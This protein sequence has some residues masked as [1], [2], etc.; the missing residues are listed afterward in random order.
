MAY[1]HLIIFTGSFVAFFLSL[2]LFAKKSVT[3]PDLY[4]AAFL[5]SIGLFQLLHYLRVEGIMREHLPHLLRVRFL[6]HGFTGVFFYQHIKSG[7]KQPQS[8]K[9]LILTYL[10][11]IFCFALVLPYLLHNATF[12]RTWEFS[13]YSPTPYYLNYLI[14]RGSLLYFCLMAWTNIKKTEGQINPDTFKWLIYLTITTFISSLITSIITF[15]DLVLIDFVSYHWL[16]LANTV[17]I[18]VIAIEAIRKGKLVNTSVDQ[19]KKERYQSSTLAE[20]KAVQ[21]LNHLDDLMHSE[22]LFLKSKLTLPEIAQRLKITP[23]GVSQSMNQ[24]RNVKFNDYVNQWRIE[25]ILKKL[26][27][28]EHESKTLLGIAMESGFN[29]KSSFN[30]AFKKY[31]GETPT[32]FI[33]NQELSKK[34]VFMPKNES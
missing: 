23:Q 14:A 12:K 9:Q 15:V 24:Y 7:L 34:V 10:P 3:K 25:V 21:I 33:K 6:I 30:L 13:E 2:F 29:S 28:G 22:Q 11:A 8:K 17:L 5:L 32:T 4:L 20:E 31:T 1:A 16:H 19:K 27:Q 26:S 18:L